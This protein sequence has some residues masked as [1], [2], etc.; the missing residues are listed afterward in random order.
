MQIK[1]C[2]IGGVLV[3]QLSSYHLAFLRQNKQILLVNYFLIFVLLEIFSIANLKYTIIFKI[4][5]NI[6]GIFGK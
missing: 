1:T 6:N 4:I 3:N 2:F 5:L